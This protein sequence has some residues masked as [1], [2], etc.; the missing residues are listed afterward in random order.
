MVDS[1]SIERVLTRKWYC[2]FE[3]SISAHGYSCFKFGKKCA[4]FVCV[5]QCS[6]EEQVIL[7][8][9]FVLKEQSSMQLRQCFDSFCFCFV[10]LGRLSVT[11]T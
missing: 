10:S 8:S 9:S 6:T 2:V 7:S 4:I 5:L 1:D 11:C 3:T